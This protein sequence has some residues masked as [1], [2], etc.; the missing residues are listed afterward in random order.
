M[1]VIEFHD[2]PH[3]FVK[4]KG[5]GTAGLE[6]KLVHQLAYLEQHP[7][8]VIFIDLKKAYDAMDRERCWEILVGY[9]VGPNMIR[10]IMFFWDNA[11]CDASLQSGIEA[12]RQTIKSQPRCHPRWTFGA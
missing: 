11:T 10:L 7:L 6:A 8:F 3:V 12:V 1:Q 9:G 2:Y 5:C 4:G